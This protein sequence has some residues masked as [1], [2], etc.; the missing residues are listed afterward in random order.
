MDD[1]TFVAE[2]EYDDTAEFRLFKKQIYH[3]ALRHIFEPLRPGMTV[4]HVLR[5]G[6]GKDMYPC[7]DLQGLSMRI[8]IQILKKQILK[9]PYP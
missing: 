4:P 9:N 8:R 2:R 7:K 6:N 3:E 5:L 1:L